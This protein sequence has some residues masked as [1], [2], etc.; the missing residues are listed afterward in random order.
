MHVLS[1]TRWALF[2]QLSSQLCSQLPDL[3]HPA[4]SPIALNVLRPLVFISCSMPIEK[5]RA[6]LW[7]FVEQ[8]RSFELQQ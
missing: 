5:R 6:T 1:F 4:L 2:S 7:N 3:T 8:S